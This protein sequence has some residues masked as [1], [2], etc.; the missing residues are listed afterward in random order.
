VDDGTLIVQ[1]KT[2]DS[3]LRIPKEAYGIMFDFLTEFGLVLEHDKL[4]LFHFSRKSG[5]D[6]PSLNLGY[7]PY[8]ESNL[9]KPKAYWRY[10]GF[11]FDRKLSF[12]EHV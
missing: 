12:K 10:L 5:D 2:W 8:T 7:Q 9:L 3:N 1:S 4:E 11:Y 6:N